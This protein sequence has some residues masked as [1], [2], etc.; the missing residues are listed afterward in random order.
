MKKTSIA[1]LA[2]IGPAFG[3]APPGEAS[4]LGNNRITQAQ[5]EGGVYTLKQIR[6]T[7][8]LIFS[9]PFNKHDG[10]GDGPIDPF[11]PDKTS[12]GNRPSVGHASTGFLRTNG[13]DSQACQECHGVVSSATIPPTLGIG[14]AG[15]INNVAM[16]ATKNWDLDDSDDNGYAAYDGRL[17]NPPFLFGAGGVELVGKEMTE[18]LQDAKTLAF[19][20]PDTVIQLDTIGGVNFGTIVWDSGLGD[21][22]YSD[23][24]GVDNDL[25]VRPFGRKGDNSSIR[26]FD[27]GA[28]SFHQGMQPEEIVDD[29][30]GDGVPDPGVDNDV[31]GD[32]IVNEITAGELS[33]LHLFAVTADRPS[34]KRILTNAEKDGK[35]TFN[36]LGCATCHV[37]NIITRSRNLGVAFPEVET[38]PSANVFFSIDLTNAPMKFRAIPGNGILVNMFSDLK[39]HN[40]GAALT[41][42]TGDPNAGDFITPRLWGVAD[43]APYLHDG[44]ALTLTDAI[45]AHAGDAQFAKDNF[46]LLG[47]SAQASLIGYLRT[48]NTPKNPFSDL[49]GVNTGGPF[50]DGILTLK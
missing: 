37:P 31:D 25:V 14:G 5:I 6:K 23:V 2:L 40:L 45:I 3:Q 12:P 22:D 39:R 7:G 33:A 4:V 44:R 35:A 36:S 49:T 28:I 29:M 11:N 21:F 24:E 1:L 38:D 9:A 19:A 30:D 26:K 16:P 27:T 32:G 50:N 8:M 41:E 42:T 47:A 17:I 10:F 34:G 43:S 46:D 20:N 18:D 48:L 13:M 15:F